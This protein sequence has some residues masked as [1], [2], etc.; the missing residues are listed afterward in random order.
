MNL[1][2]R[3]KSL[4]KTVPAVFLALKDR[5]TSII[6]KFLT[7]LRGR[8]CVRGKRPSERKAD[9]AVRGA[10]KNTGEKD[11]PTEKKSTGKGKI[12]HGRIL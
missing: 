11:K 3:A 6:A 9:R 2:E 7:G 10:E 8:D 1:K 5:D 12:F 4:K